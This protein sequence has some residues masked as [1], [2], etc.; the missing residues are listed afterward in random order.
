MGRGRGWLALHCASN[1]VW[2]TSVLRQS[3]AHR[4]RAGEDDDTE[5]FENRFRATSISELIS[6]TLSSMLYQVHPHLSVRPALALE[7][8]CG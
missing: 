8:E 6:Y 2:V 5:L 3:R 4:G 7:A 1:R